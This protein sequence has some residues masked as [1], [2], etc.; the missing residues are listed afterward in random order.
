MIDNTKRTDNFP[1][2]SIERNALELFFQ[3]VDRLLIV[4]NG[5]GKILRVNKRAIEKLGYS[6]EELQNKLIF[7]LHPTERQTE[8]LGFLEFLREHGESVHRIPFCTKDGVCFP[9]NT[10]VLRRLEPNSNLEIF[11]A[12]SQE[13]E[14]ADHMLFFKSMVDVIPDFIFFK[15][16]DSRFVGCNKAYAEKFVGLTESEV[17]GKTD[18]DMFAS[19]EIANLNRQ[20]DK[21]V[22]ETGRIL[23]NEISLTLQ[24]GKTYE[25]ET[26]KTPYYDGK[27]KISGLI[28]IS[29]DITQRKRMEDSIRESELRLSLAT[30]SANIG[31]WDW[32]VQTGV[33]VF[34]SKWAEI[35]GYTLEELAPCNIETWEKLC[36]PEDLAKSKEKLQSCFS[37]EQELYE[38][39]LRIK[40]KSGHWVWVLDRG[41]VVEWDEQGNPVRMIGTHIEITDRKHFEE[42]LNNSKK[43]AELANTMKG[44]FLANMS[45]EIRTPMNGVIGFLDLLSKTSLSSDQSEFVKE[46][47]TASSSLLMIIDDILDFSKIEAG[48]L[49][50]ENIR[51]NLRTTVR[52]AIGLLMPKAKEKQLGVYINIKSNVPDEISGDPGRLRQVLNNLVSNAVK[53]TEKGE[54]N[55]N[56]DAVAETDTHATLRF[57]VID[58]GIGLK[59]EDMERLFKP[60]MQADST[61]TRRYGG[62]GLGLAITKELVNLMGGTIQVESTPGNGTTF[63][64]ECTFQKEQAQDSSFEFKL[65]EGVNILVVDDN[66]SN[67]RIIS[68]YLEGTGCRVIEAD[69]ASGAITAILANDNTGNRID[70]ALID[71]QMNIM[72]GFELAAALKAIPCAKA[73]KLV[74]LSSSAQQGEATKA[75]EY[76]FAAY[77]SKP[78]KREE[79]LD[80]MA[81]VLG[82]KQETV[83]Q[84]QIITK[85]VVNESIDAAK[86][87]ILIVEDNEMNRKIVNLMLT[88]HNYSCDIAVD[89][90][91]ALEAVKKKEYDVVFM[92]CQMPVMDGYESTRQIRA[93][94]GAKKHTRIV[95]MTA[96]AMEG[97]MEKCLVAGMDDYLSKPVNFELMFKMIQQHDRIEQVQNSYR[98]IDDSIGEF[99][100][101]TGVGEKDAREIYEEFINMLPELFKKLDQA[102]MVIDFNKIRL[103]GHQIKGASGNLRIKAIYDLA[104]QLEASAIKG[105]LD[106]CNTLITQIK[107]IFN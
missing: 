32:L 95:A 3:E 91:E 25:F 69:G 13:N 52:D 98:F 45:H 79:L 103:L 22:F 101:A 50:V 67:R 49:S 28:G 31:L 2:S 83:N 93:F 48:K 44:Q 26:I 73:I 61:T 15:D 36:N 80:C 66:A 7:D 97:D 89:G 74:M 24:D 8:A 62:T 9:S 23:R 18:Y 104:I 70:L 102:L 47:K 65:L 82:L 64:I 14:F 20:R 30:T 105:D 12:I 46:A 55:I 71:Y 59:Q 78:M 106:N 84:E 10:R 94:E 85:Y 72:N 1:I 11:Y 21:E 76:G 87:K 38:C 42:E 63:Q 43:M 51:F 92:D 53:F 58:T 86:P 4:F 68:S 100:K 5:E 56:V 27:G 40:H 88:R 37:H 60:F 96:N 75:K 107:N 35:T 39:E 77:L 17:I 34:N 16:L 29:R 81:L 33:V 99:M 41:K 90:L 57:E 54:V 19:K 6:E